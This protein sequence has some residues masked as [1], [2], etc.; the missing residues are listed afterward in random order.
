MHSGGDT[1]VRR[2]F[3]F[4]GPTAQ[5]SLKPMTTKGVDVLT[6]L[7]TFV[8][9]NRHGGFSQA[10]RALR[11]APSAISKRISRLEKDLGA[12]LFH[13]TTRK[14]TLTIAGRSALARATALVSDFDALVT[15]LRHNRS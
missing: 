3:L 5:S 12:A 11:V 1:G 14:I 15:S 9:V 10:G 7:R 4:P 2:G 8:A 6:N 13:R